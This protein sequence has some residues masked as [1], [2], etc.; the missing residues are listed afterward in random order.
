MQEELDWDVYRRYGLFVADEAAADLTADPVS[1]PELGL[2]ER[3][4]E[5]VLARRAA[6]GEIETQ[7]FKRHHSTP[8][9]RDTGAL[10]A[11]YRAVVARRIE[12][13]GRRRDIALIERPEMQAALAVRAV[14]Q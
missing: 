6:A 7:W 1:V 11:G 12:A 9:H 3:A 13:I 4:F 5:I 10:A 2:G 14:G 8:I